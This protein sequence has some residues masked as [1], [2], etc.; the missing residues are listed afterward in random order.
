V[1]IAMGDSAEVKL[2]DEI[3]GEGGA[4][5]D[6]GYLGSD[7]MGSGSYPG[8][9]FPR[10]VLS[11]PTS[12]SLLLSMDPAALFDF[13]GTFPPSSSAAATAGSAL[14][15]FHDFSCV[16]PF[17]DAGHFLGGPPP[18][19]PPA[20]AQQQGQKGGFFAPPPGSDFNDTGMSWDDEDEI[21]QSVDTSSMA[22]SASMENAAGAAAGGSGA[23]CGSGRGKK[24][25]MPAKNLMAE[26]RRRKKL[27]DR[28]YMLRSVVPKISK[29]I[30][31]P[32]S[33]ISYL[34][35]FPSV[36]SMWS[37]NVLCFTYAEFCYLSIMAVQ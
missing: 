10:D 20:A 25:G 35:R 13:N 31:Q 15:A 32:R 29:V 17:D 9:P 6:W 23:G 30:D 7:G 36:L 14:P 28:L 26:R 21:D 4:E 19:P 2:V 1:A 37:I 16:N 18:L 12:A 11:T 22:I 5:G 8:Y 34:S 33:S 24:K 3:A 27:N